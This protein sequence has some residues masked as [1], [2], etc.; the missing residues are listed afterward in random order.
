EEKS[1]NA[2]ALPGREIFVSDG[3]FR[4]LGSE[5]EVFALLQ[6]EW[7][8][9]VMGHSLE[10]MRAADHG[11]NPFFMLGE[12]RV[13]EFEA[14]ISMMF[15][16]D[17]LGINPYGALLLMPRLKQSGQSIME[18]IDLTHGSL[19]ERE[20]NMRELIRF[21][22]FRHLSTDLTAID[23]GTLWPAV[24]RAYSHGVAWD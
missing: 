6:H 18:E 1:K 9:V 23:H 24:K 13:Q 16:L 8:H 20:L 12:A 22:D 3:L 10:L 14:D 4:A 5:E 19:G 15:E 7:R 2:F 17:E 21:F 11:Y